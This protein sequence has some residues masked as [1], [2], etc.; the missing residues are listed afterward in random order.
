MSFLPDFDKS[1]GAEHIPIPLAILAGRDLS[2]IEAQAKALKKEKEEKEASEKKFK[3]DDASS[4]EQVAEEFKE[5]MTPQ[6]DDNSK[7][8]H[9]DDTHENTSPDTVG[10]G[11]KELVPL[12]ETSKGPAPDDNTHTDGDS[13]TEARNGDEDDDCLEDWEGEFQDEINDIYL[14]LRVY[15]KKESPAKIGGQLRKTTFAELSRIENLQI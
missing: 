1:A 2:D 15:T 10:D 6:T 5:E 9:A 11:K 3:P 4:T 7:K 12:V 14:G 13:D 8:D